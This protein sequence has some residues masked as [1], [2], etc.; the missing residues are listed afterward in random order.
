MRAWQRNVEQTFESIK[1][2]RGQIRSRPE[3]SARS[4]LHT[5]WYTAELPLPDRREQQ[6]GHEGWH[7]AG[8]RKAWSNV[9]QQIKRALSE[10]FLHAALERVCGDAIDSTTDANF[11]PLRLWVAHSS[12][13]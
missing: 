1:K 12:D 7:A 6:I 10:G 5:P 2:Q 4:L 11:L 13:F 3:G 9:K 8:G